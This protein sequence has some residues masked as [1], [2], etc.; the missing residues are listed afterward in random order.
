MVLGLRVDGLGSN[1]KPATLA[2]LRLA[3][4]QASGPVCS[5]ERIILGGSWVVVQVAL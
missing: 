1:P 3:E 5:R 4:L 2:R